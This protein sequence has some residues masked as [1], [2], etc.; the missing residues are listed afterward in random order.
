[1][2]DYLAR[3]HTERNHQGKNNVLLFRQITK[4]RCDKP[5][6]SRAIGR[7]DFCSAI[8]EPRRE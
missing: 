4:T 5:V 8:I 3:Y 1:M 7:V 2:N 6:R